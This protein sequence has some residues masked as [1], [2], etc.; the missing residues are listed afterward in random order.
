M[1]SLD[2]LIRS[3]GPEG[4]EGDKEGNKISRRLHGRRAAAAER[5]ELRRS[6][7]KHGYR[8]KYRVSY[9]SE[10]ASRILSF[11]SVTRAPLRRRPPPPPR[12][13]AEK[14]F[15]TA[16]GKARGKKRH[17]RRRRHRNTAYERNRTRRN[18][19]RLL[20][21]SLSFARTRYCKHGKSI[22]NFRIVFLRRAAGIQMRPHPPDIRRYNGYKYIYMTRTVARYCG[23]P[24]PPPPPLASRPR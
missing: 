23:R 18:R 12:D 10:R 2:F 20:S 21:L 24:R 16:C 17:D 8:L 1:G 3:P 4:R 5:F 22:N 13:P 6:L 19:R 11:A 14:R 9:I 15:L 7:R